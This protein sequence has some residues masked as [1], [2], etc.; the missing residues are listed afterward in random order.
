MLGRIEDDEDF[1]KK[2]RFTEK[3]CSHVSGKV[4]QHNVR[5][6]GSENSHVVIEHIRNSAKFNV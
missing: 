2:V 5:I 3:A 1:L 4:N 6:W